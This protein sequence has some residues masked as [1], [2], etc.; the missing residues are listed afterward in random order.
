MMFV[1]K[2][3][4]L[5][6]LRNGEIKLEGKYYQTRGTGKEKRAVNFMAPIMLNAL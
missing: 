2:L 1:G 3:E 6:K 5:E 4:M